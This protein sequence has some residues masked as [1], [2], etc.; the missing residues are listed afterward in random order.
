[1]KKSG[2]GVLLI[3]FLLFSVTVHAHRYM[4][5]KQGGHRD[6]KNSSGLGYY[7]YHCKGT[8]AHLHENGTCPYEE[9]TPTPTPTE[10]AQEQIAEQ[11]AMD[12]EVMVKIGLA[13]G[14]AAFSSVIA[15]G[16]SVAWIWERKKKKS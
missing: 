4:T 7:H 13:Y 10:V 3:V 16:T 9:P 15:I 14:I 2:I 1:M 5:D 6:N 12:T 8:P 11:K